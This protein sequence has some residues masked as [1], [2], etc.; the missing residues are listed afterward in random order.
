MGIVLASGSP[1]RRELLELIGFEG[2]KIIPDD[3]EESVPQGL[4][5][6][7]TVSEIALQKAKNVSHFCGDDDI[8]IAADTLVYIDGRP[9]GKPKDAADAVSMLRELSGRMHSVYTGLVLL[10]GDRHASDVVKTDVFFRDIPDSEIFAYVE[11]GEPLD[12]AGA[13]GAQGRGSVFV[14]RVEGEF[15]NVMGLPLCRLSVMLREF[16]IDMQ[17]NT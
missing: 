3:S 10:K 7:L 4:G 2:F 11:S 1:R 8:I 6:E 12:K 16:G 13:Y 15:F 9:M 5:P 14:E 17:E